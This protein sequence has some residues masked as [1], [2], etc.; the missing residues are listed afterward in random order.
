MVTSTFQYWYSITFPWQKLKIHDLATHH[1]LQSKWSTTYKCTPESVVI[2]ATRNNN[3]KKIKPVIYLQTVFTLWFICVTFTELLSAVEKI[4]LNKASTIW[5][6]ARTTRVR[7]YQKVKPKPIWLPG[8][9]DSAWQWYQLDH[10]QIVCTLL[11]TDNHAST[12][13]L[14]FY[15]PDAL[16]DTQPTVSKH[17]MCCKK[18]YVDNN[19]NCSMA[20]CPD[21][22]VP[23]KTFTYSHL[24][25]SSTIFYQLP[26]STMIHSIFPVEFMCLTV[27]LHNLSPSPLWSISWPG[28][29][30]FIYS[31]HFFTQSL[32]F[33][34]NTCP[35]HRNLFCH[36]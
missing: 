6:L 23:E 7:W 30:H 19:N 32:S 25:W 10:M 16:P 34:C 5:I 36:I 35:N 29:L 22:P 33:F 20:L 27:F 21:K 8:A 3:V 4:L 12:S 1:I 13:S 26:P 24:S 14:S 28:N 31:I 15:R 9:R 11:Q 17:W 2:S 18:P